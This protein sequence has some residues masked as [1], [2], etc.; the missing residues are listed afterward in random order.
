M[1][2]EGFFCFCFWISVVMTMVTGSRT[3]VHVK[4]RSL[5]LSITHK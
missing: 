5:L 2:G 3:R 1:A 4:H